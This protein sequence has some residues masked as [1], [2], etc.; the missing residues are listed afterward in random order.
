MHDLK[1]HVIWRCYLLYHQYAT[2]YVFKRTLSQAAAT[3]LL[4]MIKLMSHR[5]SYI[6]GSQA[7]HNTKYG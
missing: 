4:N 1:L 7:M 5:T 3:A 6:S 2:S